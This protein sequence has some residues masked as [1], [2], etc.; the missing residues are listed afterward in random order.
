MFTIELWTDSPRIE[1]L[2]PPAIS[3]ESGELASVTADARSDV[4]FRWISF[5]NYLASRPRN[6]L[7]FSVGEGEGGSY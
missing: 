5:W 3:G 6:S 7:A 4:S 1:E 2:S